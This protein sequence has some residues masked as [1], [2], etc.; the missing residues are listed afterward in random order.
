[1]FPKKLIIQYDEKLLHKLKFFLG[2]DKRIGFAYVVS[3]RSLD[4]VFKTFDFAIQK[5]LAA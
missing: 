5:W 2:F 3:S 1:M 4:V